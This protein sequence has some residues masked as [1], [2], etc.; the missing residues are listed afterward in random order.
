VTGALFVAGE[1]EI[2]VGRVID[3][4]EDGEDGTAGITENL[5]D[6][7]TEHHLMEDLATGQADEAASVSNRPISK[8]RIEH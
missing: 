6:V 2:K 4:V 3:G 8:T 1:D 7:V 5:L